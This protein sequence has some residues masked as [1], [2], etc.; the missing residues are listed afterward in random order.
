MDQA[1]HL[2]NPEVETG[3]DYSAIKVNSI[4]VFGV[5]SALTLSYAFRLFNGSVSTL[6]FV[7]FLSAAALFL[8]ALFFKAVFIKQRDRVVF[9]LFLE[10][11]ALFSFFIFDSLGFAV[12]GV[13]LNFLFC[14]IACYAGMRELEYSLKIKIWRVARVVLPKGITALSFFITLGYLALAQANAVLISEDAFNRI[15]L[16]GDSVVRYFFPQISLTDTF[17]D[18]A[19]KYVLGS[20]D[21][22]P[23]FLALSPNQKI[24]Q[25]DFAVKDLKDLVTKQYLG[26]VEFKETDSLIHV[27]YQSFSAYLQNISGEQT[28]LMLLMFGAIL[29]LII[30]SLG[31]IFYF[32]VALLAVLSYEILMASG[33]GSVVLE[34]VSKETIVVR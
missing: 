8:I 12:S 34:T 11:L 9:V 24:A 18:A 21:N 4:A 28:I 29:F 14:L 17:S 23:A 31:M 3:V 30:R 5:A 6:N 15:V 25:T 33:F 27:L 2:N 32:V 20:L 7:F 16:P 22:S 26:G 10:N 19:Q 1:R 13:V